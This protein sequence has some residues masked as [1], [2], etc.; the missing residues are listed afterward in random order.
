MDL[1][2]PC[3]AMGMGMDFCLCL[4]VAVQKLRVFLLGAVAQGTVLIT[5]LQ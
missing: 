1:A 5:A 2:R 4:G 3:Q